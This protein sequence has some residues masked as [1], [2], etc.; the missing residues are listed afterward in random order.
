MC[1]ASLVMFQSK[2]TTCARRSAGTEALN[3]NPPVFKQS[4]TRQLLA[5]YLAAACRKISTVTGLRSTTAA[6]VGVLVLL[7]KP[8]VN[9]F[10]SA[11][12]RVTIGPGVS[13]SARVVW[14]L[15]RPWP[16]LASG[17]VLLTGT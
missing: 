10:R 8:V 15:N 14:N 9:A 3:W 6:P 4:P 1:F 7:L 12:V 2:R 16:R 13:P 5:G 11:G 17:T